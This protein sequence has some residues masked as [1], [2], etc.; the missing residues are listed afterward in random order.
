MPSFQQQ[1]QRFVDHIRDPEHCAIPDGIED[2]RMQIY[3]EL[4]FNNILGFLDN[5]FPVL[6]SLYSDNNWQNLA[7]QFFVKHSCVSPHFVDI[8]GEFV[9]FLQ[10]G[11]E[12]TDSDPLFLLELAHYEWLELDISIRQHIDKIVFWEQEEHLGAI[13]FSPLATLVSYQ[14]PVHRISVDFQPQQ[15]TEYSYLVVYRNSQEEVNFTEVN[16]LTAH[17]L[18]LVQQT[19]GKLLQDYIELIK[20]ATPNMPIEQLTQG[21]Q[22]IVCK[23]LLQQILIPLK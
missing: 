18:T 15:A 17:L 14:F 10:H 21:T 11:Y 1:Q 20:A 8:S 19:P 6:K 23:L 9:N 13:G 2:R 5:G 12:P 16:A 22:Q 7:R 4:F 3:R